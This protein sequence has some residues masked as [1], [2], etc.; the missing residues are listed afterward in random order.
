MLRPVKVITVNTDGFSLLKNILEN[1]FQILMLLIRVKKILI[2]IS[3]QD[4]LGTDVILNDTS[5]PQPA[6]SLL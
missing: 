4:A 3:L 6:L 1:Y 5:M 2:L